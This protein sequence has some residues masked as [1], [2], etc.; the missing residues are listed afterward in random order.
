[1]IS[2][3]KFFKEE[4]RVSLRDPCRNLAL[5]KYLTFHV[6][7]GE[8]ILYLWQN[9]RTVVIGKNQNAW[10]ECRVSELKA[11]GGTLVRRLSGGG[12]VY[13]DAGNLNF[14]FCVRKP[15]Y[16]VSRQLEVILKAVRGL[17]I[18]AGKSG[19]NDLTVE[20][21]KFS[22]NA[23][24]TSGEFC[25]HH[26]TILL[27]VDQE[28]MDRYLN[29]SA[30]KLQAR[31]VDSVRSRVINLKKYCPQITCEQLSKQLI[32]SF[33]DVYGLPVEEFSENLLDEEEI[34]R[35]TGFFA[36]EAWIFGRKLPFTRK[37]EERFS[38]G[39]VELLLDVD[40]GRVRDCI[41]HSD[42][43]DPDYISA[44]AG[45]IKGCRYEK[46]ELCSLF[47]EEAAGT[48]IHAEMAADILQLL[49]RE[50]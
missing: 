44:L 15:D 38:W 29:V 25:Y 17:G 11:D 2:K 20:G 49:E 14:T 28:A 1:M 30:K 6:P 40:C 19:R 23:F 7:E 31:G 26:G 42:A 5:E 13:H 22:G 41:C 12:A 8:C 47:T 3:L 33:S 24:Y 32:R 37:L 10:K 9:R 34:L 18:P 46:Q 50:L 39:E 36:S 4:E 27:D 21:K 43:M 45:R 35:D 48:G 16:D